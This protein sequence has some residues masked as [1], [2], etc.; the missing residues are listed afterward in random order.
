MFMR[1]KLK[2]E[3]NTIVISKIYRDNG[4][5]YTRKN[6]TIIEKARMESI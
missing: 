2:V 4:N 5:G 6:F 3:R 1:S